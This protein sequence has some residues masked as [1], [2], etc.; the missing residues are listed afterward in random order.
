MSFDVNF[1]GPL[2]GR[3]WVMDFG[4]FHENGLKKELQSWFD[5]T[6]IIAE[7]DP[8]LSTFVELD[9]KGLIHL[10]TMPNV[11]C[12]MFAQHVFHL[13]NRLVANET[14]GRVIVKKVRCIET[15]NNSATFSR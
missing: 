12:E 9:E 7:D 3:N 6:T 4:A 15:E 8:E 10:R 1:A 2:D 14:Q 13:V 5:H 11:G